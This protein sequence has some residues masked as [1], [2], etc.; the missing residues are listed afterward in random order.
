[1]ALPL[2][3]VNRKVRKKGKIRIY[4][5]RN[6]TQK[7]GYTPVILVFLTFLSGAEGESSS[8]GAGEGGERGMCTWKNP[9]E[10]SGPIWDFRH[11]RICAC[12]GF[13]YSSL[14]FTDQNSRNA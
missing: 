6:H 5:D 12:F 8:K 1:V 9:V 10:V 11:L 2:G 4:H 14:G 3:P 13:R 7:L